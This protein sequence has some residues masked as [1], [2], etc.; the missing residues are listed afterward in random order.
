MEQKINHKCNAM[1]V[2]HLILASMS[3]K[4]HSFHLAH[5]NQNEKTKI[6]LLARTSR[7]KMKGDEKLELF[8]METYTKSNYGDVWARENTARDTMWEAQSEKLYRFTAILSSQWFPC[9]TCDGEIEFYGRKTETMRW[10]EQII[11]VK[12]LNEANTNLFSLAH[13]Q[14]TNE[15]SFSGC[16]TVDRTQHSA[17]LV[18]VS[19][20][21]K[22]EQKKQRLCFS[23]PNW[24]FPSQHIARHFSAHARSLWSSF[25]WNAFRS[26]ETW[27]C[28]TRGIN[29]QLTILIQK[30]FI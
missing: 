14:Q 6:I 28:L 21:G 26:Y 18:C 2:E 5:E 12:R 17:T 13:Q 10:R 20:W 15:Q 27:T 7:M 11:H 30:R 29:V 25:H 8:C 23:W 16:R 1:F 9:I 19:V 24:Q 4:W 22:I 3:N